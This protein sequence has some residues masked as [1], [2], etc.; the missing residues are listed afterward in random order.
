MKEP[1][2]RT[3]LIAITLLLLATSSSCQAKESARTEFV[4]G[5]VCTV[6]LFEK[7]TKD[8][9][10][11]IFARLR[12]IDACLSANREDSNLAEIN[13]AAG[14]SPV[15]AAPDTLKVLSEALAFSART[16]GAFDPAIGP[17]VKLWNIGTDFAAVPA[18]DDLKKAL[19]L[20]SWKDIALDGRAGTVFLAKKGMRLDLGAIAKGFAAD[21]VAQIVARR[22]IKRAMIDLG[23]NIYAIGEKAPGKPWIIGIRDPSI[24]R[25]EPIASLPVINKTIVTSGIYERYFEKDGV[26]YHHILDPKTGYPENN[27][28]LS[29]TIV[30][31]NSMDADALSTSTFLL[32]TE[33]GMALLAS[34]PGTE[35]IFISKDKKIRLTPGLRGKVT[36]LDTRFSIVE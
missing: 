21:E 32:G 36:I 26:H 13:R 14:V 33:R 18:P 1:N 30:T 15:K 27:E 2:K 8:S 22:G 28:L 25:G 12:A 16:D 9:Y 35:G 3:N 24:S 5:T 23:G 11:E 34:L 7:G 10:D 19:A 6:N 20:V 31:G 29:V 4:L 17:V